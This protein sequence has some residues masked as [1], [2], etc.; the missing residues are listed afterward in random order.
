[1]PQ[2]T[3]VIGLARGE[4]VEDVAQIFAP[5]K[6]CGAFCSGGSRSASISVAAI[7]HRQI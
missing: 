2:Q 5:K 7:L 1:M 3:R 4:G 6:V